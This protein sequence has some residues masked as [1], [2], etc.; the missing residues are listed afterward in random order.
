MSVSNFFLLWKQVLRDPKSLGTVAP[1]SKFLGQC[2]VESAELEPGQRI[3]EI[4]A[5]TGPLTKWIL[6]KVDPNSFVILE[7]NQELAA[8][9][10]ERFNGVT[11]W[12]EK[13]QDLE[14]I[15][16]ENEWGE[17]DRVLSSLP[18]S[19]FSEEELESGVQ[20]ISSILNKD[21][22]VLTLVYS[23]AQ[24]F[25]TSIKLEKLFNKFFTTV[26]RSKTIWRNVP[27]GYWLVAEKPKKSHSEG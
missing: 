12:E 26:Y 20:A 25:Q 8:V 17:V 22:R 7:P 24:Y 18:W 23:H 27:P 1:S 3:M 16:S 10:R 5:G 11:V 14:T 21:G 15:C 4:G 2:L 13:V 6:P 9:I 19:L